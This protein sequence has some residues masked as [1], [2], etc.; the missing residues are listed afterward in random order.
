MDFLEKSVNRQKFLVPRL[1][2]MGYAAVSAILSGALAVYAEGAGSSEAAA[3]SV[4]RYLL[5]F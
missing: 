3:S 1:F 5:T 4:S 2:L